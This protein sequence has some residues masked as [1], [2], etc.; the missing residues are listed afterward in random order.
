MPLALCRSPL[1]ENSSIKNGL[2][3]DVI[4]DSSQSV[5]LPLNAWMKGKIL[6][7]CFIGLLELILSIKVERKQFVGSIVGSMIYH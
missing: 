5:L 4:T 3:H 6:Q 7:L 2:L 1:N